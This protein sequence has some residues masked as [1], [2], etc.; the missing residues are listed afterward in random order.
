MSTVGI[1]IAII[2]LGLAIKITFWVLVYRRCRRNTHVDE[3][4]GRTVT[5]KAFENEAAL[6][7]LEGGDSGVGFDEESESD[8]GR[9]GCE[10][11]VSAQSEAKTNTPRGIPDVKGTPEKVSMEP[12]ERGRVGDVRE[13]NVME[14]DNGRQIAE[15][16]GGYEP[17]ELDAQSTAV[18]QVKG[19]EGKEGKG[20]V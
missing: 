6:Q 8:E 16:D 14:V 11:T 13:K 2:T 9:K 19:I 4:A 17:A 20:A 1:A 5:L 7:K 10:I 12:D 3:E 18:E 15:L